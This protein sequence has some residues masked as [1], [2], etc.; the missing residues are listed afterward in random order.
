MKSLNKKKMGCPCE[1]PVSPLERNDPGYPAAKMPGVCADQYYD[2]YIK[3][4]NIRIY[5]QILPISN[6]NKIRRIVK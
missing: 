3:S 6:F 5:W 4:S 2:F 1:Q